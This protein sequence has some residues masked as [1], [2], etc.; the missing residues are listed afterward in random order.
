MPKRG[1]SAGAINVV[2]SIARLAVARS[3]WLFAIGN[4]RDVEVRALRQPR[5]S[6]DGSRDHRESLLRGPDRSTFPLVTATDDFTGHCCIEGDRLP[7]DP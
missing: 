4:E 5:R 6:Q 3:G 2:P 7:S 1:T